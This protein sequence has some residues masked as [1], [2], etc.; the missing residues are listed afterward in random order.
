[1]LADLSFVV[2]KGFFSGELVNATGQSK[3]ESSGSNRHHNSGYHQGV[4]NRVSKGEG[5][6]LGKTDKTRKTPPPIIIVAM[7]FL[8]KCL[9]INTPPMP[10][11]N[12]TA[13]VKL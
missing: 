1:M 5:I 12:R 8:I 2:C 4:G 7:I 10:I 9:A 6:T 13:E 3:G 11:T